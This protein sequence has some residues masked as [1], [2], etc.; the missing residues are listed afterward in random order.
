MKDNIPEQLNKNI[1]NANQNETNNFKLCKII[2]KHY[3]ILSAFVVLL[4]II[5]R[6]IGLDRGIWMDEMASIFIAESEYFLEALRMN[7]YPPSYF[8]LLR[9]WSSISSN[10]VHLRQLSVIFGVLSIIVTMVWIHHY[11]KTASL[12]AGFLIASSPFLIQYSQEIQVYPLL[13][14]SSACALLITTQIKSKGFHWIRYFLLTIILSIAVTTH[15]A[16]SMLLG[17]IAIYLLPD[18]INKKDVKHWL[19]AVASM[20][21]PALVFLF[22]YWYF[23]S[24]GIEG[25]WWMPQLSIGLMVR[26][27]LTLSGLNY[28][29][30]LRHVIGNISWWLANLYF[31]GLIFLLAVL[32]GAIFIFGNWRKSWQLLSI[33]A[34]IWL[35]IILV[36]ILFL[37]IFYSRILITG[38]IPLIGF[39]SV[40]VTT[41]QIKPI[42]QFALLSL[43]VVFISSST[44]WLIT[45]A[46]EPHEA[47]NQAG[48]HME[49]VY[50]EGDFV[51]IFPHYVEDSLR[52]YFPSLI[53]Q[54]VIVL[55]IKSA[56]LYQFEPFLSEDISYINLDNAVTEVDFLINNRFKSEGLEQI[57][58]YLVVRP[59]YLDQEQESYEKLLMYLEQNASKAYPKLEFTRLYIQSYQFINQISD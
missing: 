57:I 4:G 53:D 32:A 17:G 37:P 3:F 33:A 39:I 8:F 5:I 12:L 35:Q 24:R 42:R 58:F 30:E 54:D 20:I 40:Q 19:F 13:V 18:L 34:V 27:F 16:G 25:E 50:Q 55:D 11:S 31:I 59:A 21:I 10:E 7:N 46:N 52:Y 45:D 41:I 43:V 29:V 2:E 36:S 22:S 9:L 49:S 26:H 15:M 47:W 1:N 28:L 38:L 6:Q 14:L 44:L 23:A 48:E 51:A 56:P